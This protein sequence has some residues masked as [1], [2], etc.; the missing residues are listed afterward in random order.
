MKQAILVVAFGTTIKE[1]RVNNIDAVFNRIKDA[2]ADYDCLLSFSSRI[3]VKRLRDRGEEIMTEQLAME[4]LIDAGY[5]KIYVQPLHF[6]GGGEYEKLKRNIMNYEGA[7]NL[8]TLIVGRPLNFYMAQEEHPDDY[9]LFIDKFIATLPIPEGE[10]L[11]LVGHGGLDSGNSV[12]G[13]LQCKL[14][15]NGMNHVRIAVLENAP[16]LEDTTFNW[17]ILGGK[18]PR[19]LHVHPLLLVCGDHANNDLFGDEDDSVIN[20]LRAQGYEVKIHR[21]GLGEYRA[22]QDLYVEHVQDMIDDCY[23]K[24]S[25]HRPVI[26]NIK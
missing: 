1:A 14:L 21:A 16:Y 19:V 18:R 8:T 7:G 10:G 12:Y 23:G 22:I 24:R 5:E 15:L 3:I 17:E 13:M 26:P 2:Y 11:V 9:Q 6:A 4:Q 25:T 20:Q